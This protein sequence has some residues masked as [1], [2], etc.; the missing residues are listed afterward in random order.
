MLNMN[1]LQEGAA[2]DL[3]GYPTTQ[4]EIATL[5]SRFC[6]GE[7]KGLP[8]S[9]QPPALE[10]QYIGK[11]LAGLNEM[12]YLTINSQP[13]VNGARSNDKTFGW[14]PPNGY[15]YQKVIPSMVSP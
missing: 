15:V 11:Q 9:D 13:A 5:F 2:H 14:G 4:D 12:G 6:R 1:I 3:W 7:L 8:W 10:T